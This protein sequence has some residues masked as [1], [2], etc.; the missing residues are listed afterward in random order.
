MSAGKSV[1]Y[2]SDY[3]GRMCR[4][5][6]LECRRIGRSWFVEE[7]SL[8]DFALK[9]IEEKEARKGKLSKQRKAEYVEAPVVEV[10]EVKKELSVEKPKR[11]V[12]SY[13]QPPVEN[14]ESPIT[15]THFRAKI[16]EEE[17]KME[18][19]ERASMVPVSPL[20]NIANKAMVLVTSVALVFGS[21]S[22]IDNRYYEAAVTVT[23][24]GVNYAVAS[25]QGI[26]ERLYAFDSKF[27]KAIVSLDDLSGQSASSIMGGNMM[28]QAGAADLAD[29]IFRNVKGFFSR[30]GTKLTPDSTVVAT[31][32]T[33]GIVNISVKSVAKEN[34]EEFVYSEKART[35]STI[36][37]NIINQP[38]VERIVE[39]RQII[40]EGGITLAQLQETENELRKD[41]AKMALAIKN[42]TGGSFTNIALTQRID[43]LSSVDISGSTI[44]S[45][46]AALTSL[47]VSGSATFESSF[48]IPNSTSLPST[49]STGEL[50]FDTDATTGERLYACE[51]ADSW[52][53]QGGGGG[54][55][56]TDGGTATYLTS[57]TDDLV[58]GGSTLATSI[59][60]I[61]ES[62]GTFLFG[63][64]Q[65]ANPTLTFEATDGDTGDFGFNTSDAFYFTGANVG[66]GTTTP[67]EALTI[68]GAISLVPGS[69]PTENEGDI[70][71]NSSDNNLYFY[72]GTSWVDLTAAAGG[73]SGDITAV[74]SMTTGAAF[75]DS[76][77]D[78]DWLGLGASAGRI[79]FDNQATDEVN[80]LNANVGIG[81]STPSVLLTVGA[82][83]TQQFLVSDLGVITDGVWNGTAL[84]DAYVPDDITIDLAATATALATARTIA[85]VSFDGTANISLN[86]NAITNGAGYITATLTEEEVEDFV[87]GMLGGTETG[88]TVTYQDGTNDIDFEVN[89][90]LQD[91][92]T[93]GAPS[94]DGEILVATGAG[95]FAYESGATVRTSLGLTIGTNVQAYDADLTTYAG[96]TPSANV[97]SLLGAASYAAA[98]TLLDLEPGTDFYSIS[99]ADSAFEAE[100]TNSAG[101]LAALS[102]ETGT[103]LAVFSTA[104]TFTTSITIGSAGI[105][106][107]ELEI[108]DGATLT[109]T[110]LNYV[111][112][113]TSAIQ[114]QLDAK[115]VQ[116]DNEAGLYAALSDV[117]N[118]LQTGDALAG[119]D[120]TDGSIDQSEIADDILDFV[121]LSDALTVDADTTIDSTTNTITFNGGLLIASST[122]ATTT[123]ALYNTGGTLYWNGSTIGTTLTEEEVEDFVG[124]MLGGTETGITVTYQDGTNDIDFEVNGVLQDLNTLGAASTDGEIIVATGAGAF[125]YESGATVRTSLGLTIGTNVQAYDADLTTYAGITPSA[126]VQSILGAANYAAA[127]TLLDLEPGTDFYSIS[128]SD[129]AHEAELT[130]S[131]GLLA[132]L[133]DETGTGL[134]VFSTAPTFTTSI[135]IGSAGI[136]EA[137]L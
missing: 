37:Q 26:S 21:Y 127:R 82:T 66:I 120:I 20:A 99:A 98:R 61:D 63:G 23:G 104:P 128:A 52:V 42:N 43:R 85:G 81:T 137:E 14:I 8:K 18:I 54:G 67:A 100:L 56:F 78:D 55:L 59:F 83:S 121:D 94:T 119:D 96:I 103:G 1:G 97:Q 46:T 51:S 24:E 74:G 84:T 16:A 34:T 106:E 40:R 95:A 2:T 49:C 109:T 33:R 45:S 9:Q 35:P 108:L 113:V 25:L 22:V 133:S 65:S 6:S 72:D 41:I 107:A 134:A 87:G 114:T 118:F 92:N 91:L 111:D 131:A 115:E 57:L 90:V 38:V 69:A 53:L 105:S 4:V 47:T 50:Y 62:S 5:G 80:I 126:N 79:E 76:T 48:S 130:N 89:G 122:P 11:E 116:L 39:T 135:T 136:S 19:I 64:D 70:Y 125:A 101:L 68:N 12:Y 28:A 29:S 75:A 112:G 32:N 73:G 123:A 60:S 36:V 27:S 44:T 10:A 71:A 17:S 88:I 124:G 102:D 132:A 129:A 86:N 30:L 110:E 77:A 13:T 15:A 31:G 7:N 117:T 58:I 3:V 93:L